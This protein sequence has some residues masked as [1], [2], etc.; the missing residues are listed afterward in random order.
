MKNPKLF[1][2]SLIVAVIA[3]IAIVL[4]VQ[5]SRDEPEQNMPPHALDQSG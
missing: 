2:G 5:L 4:A 3:A 1:I